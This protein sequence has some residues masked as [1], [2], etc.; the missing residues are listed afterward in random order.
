M[1][2]IKNII[3]DIFQFMLVSERIN[4][5]SCI[6]KELDTSKAIFDTKK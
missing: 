5:Q 4:S 1:K 6:V 3:I 2:K